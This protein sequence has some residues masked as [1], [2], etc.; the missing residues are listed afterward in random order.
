MGLKYNAACNICLKYYHIPFLSLEK[1]G[2]L[3]LSLLLALSFVSVTASFQV[4]SLCS[5]NSLSNVLHHIPFLSL[6]KIGPLPLSLLLAL[7]CVSVAASFQVLSLCSLNSLS[8][9]LHHI[10]CSLI[11]VYLFGL[12]ITCLNNVH[13]YFL[14][15]FLSFNQPHHI[16]TLEQSSAGGGENSIDSCIYVYNGTKVGQVTIM[17]INISMHLLHTV[18]YTF[19]I[20]C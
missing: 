7:S 3:P 10:L 13:K 9:V 2:P 17:C 6:E 19:P 1:I 8:N 14:L 4:L 18:L 15:K 20:W 11:V 16:L 5:L 12:I